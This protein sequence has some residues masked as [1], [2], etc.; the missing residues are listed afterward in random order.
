MTYAEAMKN[1]IVS[2]NSDS[3]VTIKVVDYKKAPLDYEPIFVKREG[4]EN[5]IGIPDFSQIPEKYISYVKITN[6][7]YKSGLIPNLVY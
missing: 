1:Q 3:T 5:K 4:G 2:F 7:A 6:Y